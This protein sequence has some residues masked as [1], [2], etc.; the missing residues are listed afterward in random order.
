MHTPDEIN[1]KLVEVVLCHLSR[2]LS[3]MYGTPVEVACSAASGFVHWRVELK[4]PNQSGEAH[5]Y[6]K[7]MALATDGVPDAKE[8]ANAM[9]QQAVILT[10][11]ANKLDPQ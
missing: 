7:A 6:E 5:T 8:Q 3:E 9:R 1:P 11:K 4:E 10:A 2:R